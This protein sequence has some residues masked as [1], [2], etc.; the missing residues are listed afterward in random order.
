MGAA[1]T[2]MPALPAMEEVHPGHLS[3]LLPRLPD[4]TI[5]RLQACR[6]LEGRLCEL[7]TGSASLAAWPGP[8]MLAGPARLALASR[9]QIMRA[10]T[11]MGAIWHAASV[12]S[13]ISSAAVAFLVGEIGAEARSAALRHASLGVADPEPM[14]P[15][16]LVAAVAHSA[17]ACLEFWL[18]TLPDGV[19]QR[20]LLKL[21]P[22]GAALAGPDG[23]AAAISALVI[24]DI[25][26][27]AVDEVLREEP[28][29]AAGL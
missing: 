8:D 18:A 23:R 1:M 15:H 13:C 20:V 2:G 19:R 7:L 6:R 17:D 3:A 27:S 26:A 16:E 9:G 11:V 21:P 25:I 14:T 22:R 5:R 4:T 29:D 24:A 28:P 12:R 10:A